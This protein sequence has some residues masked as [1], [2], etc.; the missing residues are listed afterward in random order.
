MPQP[1]LCR[2]ICIVSLLAT[3]GCQ[4]AFDNKTPSE[5][6]PTIKT[7]AWDCDRIG[8]LVTSPGKNQ[9]IWVFQPDKTS[10]LHASTSRNSPAFGSADLGISFQNDTATISI[11]GNTDSCHK[12]YRASI[13][14]EAKLRGVEFRGIGNEPP[15]QLEIGPNSIVLKTGYELSAQTYP[16]VNSTGKS[17][18]STRYQTHTDN[19][20]L[21]ISIR[22]EH[23]ADSMSGEE[24]ASTVV[25][26]VDKLKLTGCGRPLH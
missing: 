23:C 10:Q 5:N 9:N 12:N 17:Q 8:Y 24:F 20:Q 13:W 7:S 26:S 14:E 16:L 15:W 21:T 19:G 25:I 2:L 3:H 18:Q 6:V 4:K 11:D 1:N 22:A